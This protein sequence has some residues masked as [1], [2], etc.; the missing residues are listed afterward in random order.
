MDEINNYSNQGLKQL[1]KEIE[2]MQKYI[3]NL[4]LS[5]NQIDSL[6]SEIAKL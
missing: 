1:P 6:P 3:E 4:N 5:S 2:Q